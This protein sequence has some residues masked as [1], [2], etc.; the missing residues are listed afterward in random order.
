MGEKLEGRVALVT[1]GARGQGAAEARLFAEEGARVLIADVLDDEGERLAEEIGA[2]ATYHHLDVGDEQEWAAAVD[3]CEAE[4]GGLHVL[5]NNA[6]IVRFNPLAS[7]SLAEYMEVVRV[8]QVG[9]FLGIRAAVPAMTKAGRGSI[10]NVS[11]IEGLSGMAGLGAYGATKFAV[12]GM[13]KVAAL[14]LGPVGIRVNSIHPGAI[15]TPMLRG[16]F[17][18][19]E[20]P[21]AMFTHVPL[22]RAGLSEEVARLAL[23]LSCDDSSYC[24]GSEFVIDG[25]WLAG[26]GMIGSG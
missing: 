17:G 8:N 7:C 13:T 20:L 10:I 25:G 3:R 11:S 21:P 16:A 14:E 2:A 1:G 26:H 5:V 24:T 19:G 4:L 22:K 18:E 12:R 23:F 6:G 15:D 9:V